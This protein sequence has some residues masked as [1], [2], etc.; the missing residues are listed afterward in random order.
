[1]PGQKKDFPGL[2]RTSPCTNSFKKCDNPMTLFFFH[3][4]PNK[5]TLGDAQTLWILGIFGKTFAFT[6]CRLRT[7]KRAG[8]MRAPVPPTHVAVDNE[9]Q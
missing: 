7:L 8:V 2:R 5:L 3:S 6:S 1:M 9:G 4:L